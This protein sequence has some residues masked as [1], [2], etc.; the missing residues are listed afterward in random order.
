MM[1]RFDLLKWL[2]QYAE[3]SCFEDLPDVMTWWSSMQSG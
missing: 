3:M 1:R 2:A